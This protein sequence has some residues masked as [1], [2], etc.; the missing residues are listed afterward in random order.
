[1]YVESFRDP[2]LKYQNEIDNEIAEKKLSD[3]ESVGFIGARRVL[4]A[5]IVARLFASKNRDRHGQQRPGFTRRETFR[6]TSH[7]SLKS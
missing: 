4:F 5:L 1:M 6:V 2:T 7:H 3:G